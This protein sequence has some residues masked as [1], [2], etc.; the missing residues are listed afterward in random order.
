M[1]SA[2][3]ALFTL[4]ETD[5]KYD[6]ARFQ[7]LVR[8]GLAHCRATAPDAVLFHCCLPRDE[9]AKRGAPPEVAETLEALLGT[10]HRCFYDPDAADGGIRAMLVAVAASGGL[11]FCLTPMSVRTYDL[12][13]ELVPWERVAPSLA[14]DEG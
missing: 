9:L 5:G 11:L 1:A 13:R 10:E 14:I 2:V 12:V 8:P 7:H 6:P 4:T 3:A